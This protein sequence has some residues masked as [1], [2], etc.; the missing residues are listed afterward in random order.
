MEKEQKYL[1]ELRH[2]PVRLMFHNNNNNVIVRSTTVN[3]NSVNNTLTWC[4]SIQTWDIFPYL[5]VVSDSECE[6]IKRLLL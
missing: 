1:S 4:F 2:T 5:W 6:V 3:Q